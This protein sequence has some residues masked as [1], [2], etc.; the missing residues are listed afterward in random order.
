MKKSVLLLLLLSTLFTTYSHSQGLKGFKLPNGLT[1]YIWED[2]TKP[3]VFGMVTVNVGAASDPDNLTGLAHYLEHV[4]FKG[5]EKIGTMDW[6]KEKPIYE[7]I[8]AKYDELAATQDAA[9]REAISLEINKLTVEAAQYMVGNEFSNLT[10]EMGGMMLNAQ[11]GYDFTRYFNLFPPSEIYRWLELNSERFINPVFRA[12]Q[13]ELETVYEEYNMG[14]DEQGRQIQSFMLSNIFP[15]HPY[16]RPVV[17]YPE[18]LKNPQLSKLIDF[19]N[20]WYVPENMVLILVGN[21]KA[22]QVRGIIQDK[23]GRLQARQ[24]PQQKENASWNIKG[25][26]V[27]STKLTPYPMLHLAFNGVPQGHPDEIPLEICMSILSNASQTG[28]LDKLTLE[29]DFMQASAS[30][31]N[32][33]EQ[34]RIMISA[35]PYFDINQRRFN[36]LRDTEKMLWKELNK[37]QEGKIEEWLLQSIKST[38]IRQFD[39]AFE[40]SMEK[41][42]RLM[43]SFI[44]KQD[45]SEVLAYKDRVADISLDEIKA[46]AKK[47]L[48]DDFLVLDIQEGKAPKSEKLEKPGYDPITPLR[49]VRSAY[50]NTFASL[51]VMKKE[52][53]FC[54]FNEVQQKKINDL[55]EL[56][57][58]KNEEN[59]IFTLTL[60]YGVGRALMPKL[61]YAVQL[62]NNAGIMGFYEPQEL[63]QA[64][65]ELGA[66]CR[67]R[68]DDSYLYVIMEG[69]EEN[70]QESCNLLTRQI[71]MPKLEEK[72]LNN[73]I[74]GEMQSRMREKDYVESVKDAV[75]EYLF[76]QD[77][78]EYLD[79]LPI[80]EIREMTV[81]SLTG[82]FSR[83]TDYEAEVHYVG[84]RPFD[85][86]YDIL[87]QNL[88][89]KANERPSISP[90]VKE[91][92]FYSENTIFFLPENDAQQSGIY[93]Y[94]DGKPFNIKE[95]MTISAVNQY[96][97]GGFN[98]IIIQEIREYRSMAYHTY[99]RILTPTI[100]DKPYYFDGFIGTQSDKTV[101]AIEIFLSMINE[102]PE[103]PERINNIKEYL[104][105]AKLSS[106]PTFRTASQQYEAWR[107][108]GFSEDPAKTEL[109][110]IESLTFDDLM[111]FY[112]EEIKGKPM[113]IAIVGDPKQID[114][115]QLEKFGKV[116][117]LNKNRIFSSK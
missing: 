98:G 100:P 109:A 62:M 13:S 106:K 30:L 83:A 41:A 71:L 53:E 73:I 27:V 43:E 67:F 37:L 82:E 51:P 65:S 99:G 21:V 15:G 14:Q 33:K 69:Y 11:T 93:F 34:G 47:Y 114:I 113:A 78:S 76:Y 61:D 17:G 108:L 26:K 111:K 95:R 104:Y 46:V 10:E 96:L 18:H 22:S 23:F 56:F 89:L 52:P 2:F 8:I 9:Q 72:Q 64:F 19:Y 40:S 94:I 7:Q 55:S 24:A 25:R 92:V 88:P 16:A 115:K 6:E 102:M 3:D 59:E 87:S 77:K 54:D 38:M 116:T 117:R 44:N 103:Y 20:T 50:S 60:K 32:F 58:T 31:A 39:L 57:Y 5:T 45:V 110:I 29:G 4:M 74:G 91:R 36:S 42:F 12:F 101:E 28:L 105:K 81:S 49:N 1:V 80:T 84:G 107:K 90:E 85:E 112:N 35:V 75:S 63:K 66:S 86:V 79:R 70:L 97:S 48:T 68:V